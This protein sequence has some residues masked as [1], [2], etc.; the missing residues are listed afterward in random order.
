MRVFV[1]GINGQLGHDCVGELMRRGHE[2]IGSDIQATT[3]GVVAYHQLDI[4]D[5]G[6]QQNYKPVLP[7]E[8]KSL[9]IR[10][11]GAKE[12]KITR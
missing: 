7:P 8:W 5:K 10:R 9:T 3:T 2:P 12:I 4:T 11:K 6:L 1:T